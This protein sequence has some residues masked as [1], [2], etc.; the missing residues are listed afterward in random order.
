MTSTDPATTPALQR[1][2]NGSLTGRTTN[3]LLDAILNRQFP[4]NRLPPEP[5]LAEQLAVSRTTIRAA[6]QSLERLGVLSRAPGRGT[7]VRAHVGRESIV[8]QRLIGFRGL[9]MERHDDVQVNQRYWLRDHTDEIGTRTLKVPTETPVIVSEKT[10]VADGHPA[11]H[12]S[13]QIPLQY[14]APALQEQL[15]SGG[16]VPAQDSIFEFSRSWPGREIDHTVV[17]LIPAVAPAERTTLQLEDGTPF[18]RLL[19][20]HYNVAGE[21][22]AMSEV[23]VDDRY[24]R[25]NVVRHD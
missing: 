1:V 10:F 15:L 2:G 7:M 3:T 16:E 9:L 14:C 6:L 4:D 8:L 21:P 11:I 22:V 23:H 19:E 5:E 20:T 13:D 25:F 18:M 24:V 17:E 12:I